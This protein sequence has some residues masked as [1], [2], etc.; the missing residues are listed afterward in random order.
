[1][2]IAAFVGSPRSDGVTDALVREVLRGA[3]DEGAD[4]SLFH[5]GLLHIQGCHACL[6][7]REKGM[8]VLDDDMTPLF[9]HLRKSDALVLGTPIY[10]YYMTA[11]MKAFTD[12]LFSTIDRGFSKRLGTKKAVL[13]VTQGVEDPD[14]FASQV[15]SMKGAWRLTG[16]EVQD[17]IMGCGLESPDEVYSETDLMGKAYSLGS[18]LARNDT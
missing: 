14:A 5:I 15:E 3:E 4:T 7:C 9:E 16:I 8:C 13:V 10:F 1:M 11:Q 12:R 2:K 17:T 18:S 6:K